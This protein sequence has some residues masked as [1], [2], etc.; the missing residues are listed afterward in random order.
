MST[1]DHTL[2]AMANPKPEK[3]KGLVMKGQRH[4]FEIKKMAKFLEISRGSFYYSLHRRP[5]KRSIENA[6]YLKKIKAIHERSRYIYGSPRVHVKKQGIACSRRRIAKIMKE[7]GIQA[8]T[9]L[10]TLYW[11]DRRH[12]PKSSLMIVFLL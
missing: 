9:D 5:S 8:K 6:E 2:S 10:D 11:T 3:I 7:H 12:T 1:T 4:K